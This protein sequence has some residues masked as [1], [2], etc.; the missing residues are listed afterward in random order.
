MPCSS[1]AI[2][3]WYYSLSQR[4]RLF[5]RC[6][7]LAFCG[8]VAV[9]G[10]SLMFMN[11]WVFQGLMMLSLAFFSALWVDHWFHDQNKRINKAMTL[12][13]R[14]KVIQE[15][16]DARRNIASNAFSIQERE[17]VDCFF[18]RAKIRIEKSI[19][20][21]EDAK[22]IIFEPEFLFR[23]Q[24]LSEGKICAIFRNGEPVSICDERH[25]YHDAWLKMVEWGRRHDLEISRLPD[26]YES[27]DA[28]QNFGYAPLV[29]Q[30][31]KED[32]YVD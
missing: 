11:R 19:M 29:K 14:L 24:V 23:N 25:I 27:Y 6:A 15:N 21:H 16:Q 22:P 7:I 10:M 17:D 26:Q 28:I 12:G 30:K 4:R 2:E 20:N 31:N 9:S 32:F 18:E 5:L 8:G 3:R 13:A 1:H